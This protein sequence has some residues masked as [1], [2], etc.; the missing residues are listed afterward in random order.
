MVDWKVRHEDRARSL[1]SFFLFR[2]DKSVLQHNHVF[3]YDENGTVETDRE[4]LSAKVLVIYIFELILSPR[5]LSILLGLQ[6][7]GGLPF[8]PI[9]LVRGF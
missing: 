4:G 5:M 9:S 7:I 8:P 1:L 3:L 6:Q 2:R